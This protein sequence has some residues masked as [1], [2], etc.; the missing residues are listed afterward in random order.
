VTGPAAGVPGEPPAVARG[1][2][3]LNR[4]ADRIL[5]VTLARAV[6]R[7]AFARAQLAGLDFRFHLGADKRELDLDR[8]A[9]EGALDPRPRRRISGSGRPL[10]AGQVAAALSHRQ[11]YE[12]TVRNGWR[13][14]VVLEDDVA[15]RADALAA[16]PAALE[17]LPDEF[18]LLYLGCSRFE[19]VTGRDRLRRLAYLALSP[20]RLVRWRPGEVLRLHPRPYSANLRRAGLHIGAYAYA[21]SQAGARKLLAAQTPLAHA[22]DHVL[23]Y[24]V[25][26]GELSA[27]VVEPRVFEERSDLVGGPASFVRL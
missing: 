8:L 23:P 4:W 16:L 9:R 6:E 14:V 5:V 15:P 12:L 26:S 25:L 20:L 19:R 17:Q 21:V 27:F 7:Q 13:R 24:L 11:V 3:L 10:G 18:D 2:E 1:R 22:A